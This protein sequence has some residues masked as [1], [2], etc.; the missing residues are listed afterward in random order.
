[1]HVL[2]IPSEEFLP[3]SNPMVGIFQ[4]HQAKI[5]QQGGYQLGVLSI[6]QSFSV[7]ML[8][9][10]IAKKISFQKSGNTTDAYSFGQLFK[11]GYNKMFQPEHFL[12]MDNSLGMPV[13]RI[14]GFYYKP[15]VANYNYYGWVK[16]GMS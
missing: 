8:L 13:F 2:I 10:G 4:Y 5:L 1:M 11:L 7:P 6:T 16:A 9:K 14:D 3:P 15:P 12:T